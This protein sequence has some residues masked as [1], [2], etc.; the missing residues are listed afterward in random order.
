MSKGSEFEKEIAR[1]LGLWLTQD[2]DE[3]RDDIFYTTSGSG[4]R[5]TMRMKKKVSTYNS[6]GDLSFLDPIGQPFCDYF[7]TEIKRGYTSIGRITEKALNEVISKCAGDQAEVVKKVRH[8]ISTKLKKGGDIIDPLDFIDANK[9]PI[10]LAW[11][12]KAI[13][14]ASE[15]E[16][17]ATLIIFKRDMKEISI[18]MDKH[19]WGCLCQLA[20]RY[21]PHTILTVKHGKVNLIIVSFDTFLNAIHPQAIQRLS[22]G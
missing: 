18:M 3:P 8:Y 10:L 7:F 19:V 13:K 14:E 22:D 5:H 4:S 21:V 17:P 11:W 2:L 12:E 6:A 20:V 9:K 15:S 1:T 16:R